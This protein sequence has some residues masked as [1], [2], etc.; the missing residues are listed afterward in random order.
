L[1][2]VHDAIGAQVVD[3]DLGNGTTKRCVT[4][5]TQRA[6]VMLRALGISDLKPPTPRRRETKP[7][8]SVT[9]CVTHP[10][11]INDCTGERQK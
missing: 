3:I 9:I 1:R 10:N 4:Q 6:A 5:P 7:R 2:E 11:K 8:C